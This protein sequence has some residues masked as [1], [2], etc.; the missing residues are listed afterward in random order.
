[1]LIK[2]AQNIN[3]ASLGRLYQHLGKDCLLFISAD[4][5]ADTTGMSEEEA[6]KIK[7]V[8]KEINNKNYLKLKTYVKL[9]SKAKNKIHNGNCFGYNRVLGGYKE[10]TGEMT[11][12]ERALVVYA[13]PEYQED[14]KKLGISL[15]KKFKQDSVMFVY[16]NEKAVWIG[17]REDSSV[18]GIGKEKPLGKFTTQN[19]DIYF[20]RIGHK[21]FK[22]TEIEEGIYYPNRVSYLSLSQAFDRLWETS[23]DVIRDWEDSIE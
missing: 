6:Q 3:E 19:I 12:G 22:F 10:E 9:A 4:R 11:V 2:N 18:G 5:V 21:E 8:Q 7:E 23:S 1:M 14:L 20:T 13:S 17:T 15:G 16:P